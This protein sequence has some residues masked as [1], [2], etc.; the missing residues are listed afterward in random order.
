MYEAQ[1][2][3]HYLAVGKLKNQGQ[4]LQTFNLEYEGIHVLRQ[5]MITFELDHR[6][7]MFAAADTPYVNRMKQDD[8]ALPELATYNAK[9]DVAINHLLGQQPTFV[10]V[11]KGRTVGE[12]SYIWVEQ[13]HFYAMGYLDQDTQLTSMEDIR[14][15]LQRYPGNHYMMQ[16]INSYVNKYP[17]KVTYLHD[18]HQAVVLPDVSEDY[19][20]E[21]LM[22]F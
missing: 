7:C 12:K 10:L 8:V 1:N 13:G 22:L 11:D 18:C 16:L 20:G 2:G 9:V 14:S 21:S 4:C 3:Y 6:M 15:S 17:N 19:G 5:L